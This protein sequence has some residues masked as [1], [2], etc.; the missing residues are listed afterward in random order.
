MDDTDFDIEI[1][2]VKEDGTS[3]RRGHLQVRVHRRRRRK[4]PASRQREGL[5]DEAKGEVS[6]SRR[7]ETGRSTRNSATLSRAVLRT[8]RQALAAFAVVLA[9]LLVPMAVASTWL[10]LRVDGTEAYVD[11]VAPLADEPE[12]RDALAKEVSA[13]ATSAIA[14]IVP[15]AG[16]FPKVDPYLGPRGGRERRLPGVLAL[17]DTGDSF[18]GSTEGVESTE[19]VHEG[20]KSTVAR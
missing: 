10:S 9:T 11:T 3:R 20:R 7:T 8:S 2:D 16:A 4:V 1:G 5:G 12:L 14:D 6:S 19:M 17:G 18:A 15:G 13:A